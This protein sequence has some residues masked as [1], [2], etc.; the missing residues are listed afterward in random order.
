IHT[1]ERP[2]KCGKCGKSFRQRANL[3]RHQR[4]HTGERPYECP[5]CGKSFSQPSN[6]TKHKQ[7]H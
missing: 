1:G 6:L 7:S 2:H 3:I 4:T 5:L